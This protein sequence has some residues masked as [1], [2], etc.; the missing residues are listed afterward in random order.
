MYQSSGNILFISDEESDLNQFQADFVR[1][2]NVFTASSIRKAREL[3]QNYEIHVV[4]ARQRMHEMTGSQFCE[5]LTPSFPHVKNVILSEAADTAALDQAVRNGLVYRYVQHPYRKE[6]LKMTLDGALK[7]YETEYKNRALSKQLRKVRAEQENV[8]KLFKNYIPAEVLSQTLQDQKEHHIR[9]GEL[10]VVS[11][12]LAGIRGFN[13][14]ASRLQP[15]EVIAFLGDYRQMITGCIEENMGAVNKHMGDR[16]LAVFGA[17]AS[18]MNNHENAVSAA[19]GIIDK[20]HK[21]NI[22]YAEIVGA[23]I[24]V[25]IGINSGEVV[26]GNAGTETHA[27]YTVIGDA[28]NI[29]SQMETISKQK[30]DSIIISKDTFELTNHAFETSEM[31]RYLLKEDEQPVSYYEV[32]GKRSGNI[33]NVRSR[34]GS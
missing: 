29:A 15:N 33:Y 12:L 1:H 13:R 28:V 4:V 6:D 16:L 5:G 19:L 7:L 31:K 10:R 30:P 26:V 24:T 17:P 2:Y 3:L 21:V 25:G 34:G 32:L 14:L 11:V 18:Y 27:E 9:S 20:L 22:R 23:E 8:I